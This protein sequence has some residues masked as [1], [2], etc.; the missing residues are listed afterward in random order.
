MLLTAALYVGQGALCAAVAM[1]PANEWVLISSSLMV[2][3]F[4]AL[5]LLA[6]HYGRHLYR[7]LRRV[8]VELRI[9]RK[10]LTE[11]ALVATMCAISCFFRACCVAF[12]TLDAGSTAKVRCRPSPPPPPLPVSLTPPPSPICS[13]IQ[14][15]F[16]LVLLYFV[17]LEL[18]PAA[19]IVVTHLK[20]P[21]ERFIEGRGPSF[22]SPASSVSF[23]SPPSAVASAYAAPQ[24]RRGSRTASLGGDAEAS[25]SA[26]LSAP[27]LG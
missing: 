18:F 10:K 25:A 20:R 15:P 1:S 4:A 9:I 16:P 21:P 2:V 24:A 3:A 27:L 13:P 17:L 7:T 6:L 14:M 23:A 22:S 8:P 26:A 11:V 12:A 19:V 5:A